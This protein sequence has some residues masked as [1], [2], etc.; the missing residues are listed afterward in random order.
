MRNIK[1]EFPGVIA[2]DNVNFNLRAGEIHAL[3]GENGA[4]KT[5]LVKIL[6]GLYK[7]DQGEIF[8]KGKKVE[9]KTPRDSIELGI[10]MVHQH[11]M[12]ID[13]FSVLENIV[14][15]LKELKVVIP[16]K[17]ISKNIESYGK[18]YGLKIN[19]NAKIWQ[20]SAGEK[21][22]VEIV[23]ALYRGAEILI[24]DEPTSVL[25]ESEVKPFFEMLRKMADEGKSIIF[26]THKLDEVL[27]VSN[28][29]T[30]LRNGKVQDTL[31]TSKTNKHEL[32]QMLVGRDKIY[33]LNKTRIKKG[34]LILEVKNLK[35]N[36]DKAIEALKGISFR[37]Y[38]GE[39]FGIVGIAGN[40]QRELLEAI[41]GLRKVISGD[42]FIKEENVT[43]KSPRIINRKNVAHIPEERIERGIVPNMGISENLIL[44]N[45]DQFP[46]V[47]DIYNGKIKLLL[48]NEKIKQ[49]SQKLINEYE[50]LTPDVN[51][52][53]KLL[54]GGNIQKL[55]LAREIS[56]NPSLIIASHPTY[57]L[58]IKA[59]EFIRSTL[60]SEREKG[61]AIL[62]VS[63][64]LNEIMSLSD[65]IAVIFE[66]E[67][68][69]VFE[70]EGADLQE[71]GLLMVGEKK[72]NTKGGFKY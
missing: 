30:V 7:Q 65:R 19:P 59:T 50:I 9:I 49:F 62:L 22:R 36:N 21:Q 16:R 17:E 39:I 37:I 10:G 61:V 33:R 67:L 72:F 56:S 28:R 29:V 38:E 46:I 18:T 40:G 48:N 34:M 1:K 14:L 51:T 68:V 3:L 24:L 26:I 4:G 55:I 20:L 27:S 60:L 66:G 63:E 69:K 70:A 13:N 31:K 57:G 11:F 54:S 5:T 12:L 8:I 32:T 25:A 71:I 52:P 15:G 64:D 35:V 58:D 43:N 45:Y 44:K 23:K 42:I 47:K 53:V 6:Y 2:N 41:T